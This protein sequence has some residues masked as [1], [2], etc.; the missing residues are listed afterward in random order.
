LAESFKCEE[1]EEEEEEGRSGS[2]KNTAVS[3]D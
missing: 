1:R 2:K 3:L